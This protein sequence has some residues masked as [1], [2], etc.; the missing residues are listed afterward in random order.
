M[1]EFERLARF[2]ALRRGDEVVEEAVGVE[3]RT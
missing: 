1:R 3:A 2:V